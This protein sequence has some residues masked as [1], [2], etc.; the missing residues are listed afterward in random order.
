MHVIEACDGQAGLEAYLQYGR[1]VA[2]VSLR[3]RAAGCGRR[4]ALGAADGVGRDGCCTLG[5]L[6]PPSPLPPLLPPNL[7]PPS[8]PSPAPNP[9]SREQVFMDL[10]MPVRSGMEAVLSIRRWATPA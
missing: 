3:G 7:V 6:S 2:M 8:S 10:M 5:A 4:D 1:S 9:L